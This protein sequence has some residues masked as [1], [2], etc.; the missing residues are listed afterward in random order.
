[1]SSGQARRRAR[2]WALT[3]V[4]AL[5]AST[6]ARRAV[7]EPMRLLVSVG[8]RAGLPGEAPLKHAT[9]DAQRVRD[10]LTSLGGVAPS[11]AI[12]LQEPTSAQLFAAIDRAAA[13]ARSH[14]PGEVT[15]VFYFSGHGDRERLHLGAER[16]SLKDLDA[17]LGRVPAAL[18]IVVADAC[19]TNDVRAKGV[20]VEEPFAISFDAGGTA[21]GIARIHAS[22][23]GE[24]AQESDELGGAVFTHYWL[25]GL[26]G[27]ADRDGDGRVT[28]SESYAFA[29]D[30]TLYRSARAS[31]VVQRPAA[32]F[33]VREG[34]PIV[35]TRL[36]SASAIRLPKQGDAHYVV[37]GL[38][39]RT[40]VG[41]LWGASDRAVTL[42]VPP[43]R[44]VVHRRGGG[45]SAAVEISVGR[46]ERRDLSSADFRAVSEEVLAR[47]GGEVALY[48]DEVR[49]AYGAGVSRL[50]D[51]GH[52]LELRYGHAWDSGWALSVGGRG[53]V[54]S[55]SAP[56]QE[57][58]VRSIGFDALLERRARA[59][60]FVLRVGLGPSVAGLLQTLTRTD[61]D[62]LALAG[63]EGAREF[64]GVA[65]GGRAALGA[66]L[67]VWGRAFLELEARG[68]L[69]AARL[70]GGTV[71]VGGAA[72]GLGAGT[73]F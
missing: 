48:P 35:L 29:Y 45:R 14:K 52:E 32:V 9:R 21:T 18:R 10:V 3:A 2:I 62:R 63:Y 24:V 64:R 55:R 69:A 20:T 31:G 23:D 47:K 11:N 61:A 27:A 68:D 15:L 22:A 6:W 37:Y 43:G 34:A 26:S 30:Q 28:L 50:V 59:G 73:T 7:A 17:R 38:G 19:R 58:T 33:D 42:A 51:L 44:Y 70:D 8:H 53:G 36:R 54:G 13:L 67:E 49:V 5:C 1:M 40:V 16:V 25:T 39:S 56:G 60:P 4:I 65:V 12:L 71:A 46:S 41:D 66:R 72:M 57:A